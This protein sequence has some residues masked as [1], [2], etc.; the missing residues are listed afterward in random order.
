MC[1]LRRSLIMQLHSVTSNRDIYLTA[2]RLLLFSVIRPTIE[3]GGEIWEGKKGQVAALFWGELRGFW[4]VRLK[5]V[6]KQLEVIW[7]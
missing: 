1:I 7:V 6:I 2:H 5:L 3:Y 4:V